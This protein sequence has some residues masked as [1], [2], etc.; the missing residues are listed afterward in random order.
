[1]YP[2]TSNGIF[3]AGSNW[4]QISGIN[5]VPLSEED[6][7]SLRISSFKVGSTTLNINWGNRIRGI[8][9]SGSTLIYLNPDIWTLFGNSLLSMCSHTHLIGIC[10]G[11]S[12]PGE[13]F[14]DA[15]WCYTMSQ[16]D[17]NKYPTLSFS[18]PGGTTLSLTPSQ[19]FIDC[20]GDTW[21]IGLTVFDFGGFLGIDFGDSFIKNFL[22]VFDR[23]TNQV[24]FGPFSDCGTLP[25]VCQSPTAT[26]DSATL[27][28][29]C[30]TCPQIVLHGTLDS[31]VTL[32]S[33]STWTFSH[34]SS[35]CNSV[36]SYS[37]S[38]NGGVSWTTGTTEIYSQPSGNSCVAKTRFQHCSSDTFLN[39]KCVR[40]DLPNGQSIARTV[41]VR[42]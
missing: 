35:N 38:S 4:N 42:C 37:Y 11:Y 9:D 41:S 39:G 1:L 29:Q 10:P 13:T 34:S 30:S 7:Y 36:G 14:L 16:S 20:G 25:S 27:H 32:S 15:P 6:Y 22:T 8:L 31:L 21:T 17:I 33:G 18:F 26:S 23:E 3:E 5:W 24:G 28:S 2:S 12:A 40:I 19:Y